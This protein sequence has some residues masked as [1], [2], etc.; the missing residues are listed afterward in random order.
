MEDRRCAMHPKMLENALFLRE[1]ASLWDESTVEEAIVRKDTYFGE[2]LE[3]LEG[4][5][6]C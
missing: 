3:D 2:N 6:G 4:D 5:E 1:N